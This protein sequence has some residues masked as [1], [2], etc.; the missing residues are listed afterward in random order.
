V[1]I[2]EAVVQEDSDQIT[3][4]VSYSSNDTT[5]TGLGLHIHFDSSA[6]SLTN[7]S[8]VL[9]SDAFIEPSTTAT[10]DTSDL[11]NNP[12][13]DSYILATWTSLFGSWPGT[14]PQDLMT[15]TFD[16]VE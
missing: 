9:A 2:S 16:V 8:D 4:T 14:V 15:L 1:Y 13:T 11:D 3:L 7:I 6:L 12:N 10:A 5:T